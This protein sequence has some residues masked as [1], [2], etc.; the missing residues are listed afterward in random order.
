MV[1]KL[2]IKKIIVENQ[3]R[4]PKLQIIFRK[5]NLDNHT[6]YVFVGLRRAG[7]S[8]TLFQNI[9]D[10]I[11]QNINQPADILYINFEDDR[12]V[13]FDVFDFQEIINSYYELYP[14]RTPVIYLDEIQIVEGW[15]KFARRLADQ[16]YR[17]Y[18]TG[19]NAKMLSKEIA[20]TLGGRYVPREI[21][22]FS[23]AEYLQFKGVELGENWL[24]V[25]SL[26]AKMRNLFDDYFVYGG[27]AEN[28]NSSNQ[29]EWLNILL[30]KILLGDIILRNNIR[31]SENILNLTRKLADS[32]MQPSTLNR[33]C[34]ILKS[35]GAKITRETLAQ[36]Q[37]CMQDAFLIFRI[38]NYTDS[39]SERVLQGKTY[40]YDNGLLSVCTLE[41]DTKLLENMVAIALN[42]KY[43]SKGINDLF[44]YKKGVEVDF[45]MP[46]SKKAIQ[47][48]YQLGDQQN[49]TFKRETK[50]LIE[51]SEVYE[52]T[53]FQIVTYDEEYEVDVK[54]RKIHVC[55]VW[56]WLINMES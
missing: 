50:A 39:F 42:K 9:S 54:G 24:Y 44:Y 38:K 56:K 48:C 16:Q 40:F 43:G 30:K 11:K 23:F 26:L 20:T 12:L 46:E 34:N 27:F 15:E 49:D 55:P 4:I 52:I 37:E 31:E 2:T 1:N 51:L 47:V 14:Q 19:S 21:Y 28:I 35:A 8:Y 6:N 33:L 41:A 10:R 36:Y 5:N 3:E 29:R 22:P 53:D 7:K 32:V 45:F 18:V 13:G 25:D 17:I